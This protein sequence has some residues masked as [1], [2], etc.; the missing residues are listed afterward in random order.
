MIAET[1]QRRRSVKKPRWNAIDIAVLE[2]TYP[3][4]G[5]RGAQRGMSL[6]SRPAR[7][8]CTIRKMASKMDVAY[9][10]EM[11]WVIKCAFCQIE[12]TSAYQHQVF[13]SRRC[14]QASGRDQRRRLS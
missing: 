6:R 8:N 14:S 4:Y 10:A 3:K 7:S 11:R 9:G 12:F 13:C 2:S 1:T 5:V